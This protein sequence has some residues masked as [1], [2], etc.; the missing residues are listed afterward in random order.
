[1]HAADWKQLSPATSPSARALCAMAYDPVSKKIIMFGG[2]GANGNL[3]DTWAFDGSTWTKLNTT[4]APSARNGVTMAYDRPTKK[5]VMF[6]GFSGASYLSDTWVFDGATSTWTQVNI[7]SPPPKATGA[8][9]FSDPVTGRAIMFGGYDGTRRIPVFN[10]T[11]LW[12]GTAWK[13][14]KPAT[15]PIPRAWGIATLD[16]LRHYVLMTGGNGDTLRTDNTWTWDGSNWTQQ[17][18]ATQVEQ[19]VMAAYAYDPAAQA[20]TVFGGVAETWEWDGATWVQVVPTNY[21]SSR[22]GAA[23]ATDQTTRQTILFGGE[24]ANGALK[25]TWQLVGK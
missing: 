23:M 9:L 25:E 2:V 16:P 21:P 22:Y 10:N 17:S 5:L 20:V 7:A 4:G 18:P 3:N 11:W 6:G 12:T 14:L 24:D 15:F 19:L 1:M 8:M 13:W